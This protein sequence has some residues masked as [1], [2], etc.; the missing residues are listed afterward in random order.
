MDDRQAT[1]CLSFYKSR[2]IESRPHVFLSRY[3]FRSGSCTRRN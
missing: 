2:A 3:A 1:I